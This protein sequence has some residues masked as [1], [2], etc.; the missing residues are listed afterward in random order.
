MRVDISGLVVLRPCNLLDGRV[1]AAVKDILGFS[2]DRR[3]VHSTQQAGN[4]SKEKGA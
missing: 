1:Q 2:R 3:T 4:N